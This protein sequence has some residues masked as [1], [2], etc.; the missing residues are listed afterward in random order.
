MAS[1][2]Y[3]LHGEDVLAIV[4]ALNDVLHGPEAVDE[5]ELQAHLRV[6]RAEALRRSAASMVEESLRAPSRV[7][8]ACDDDSQHG[9]TAVDEG[10]LV[11]TGRT[12]VPLLRRGEPA[13]DVP[14]AGGPRPRELRRWR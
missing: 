5:P 12:W 2:E 11:V 13:F 9:G 14:N 7:S 6:T 4:H 3:I 10:E 8:Q 1:D